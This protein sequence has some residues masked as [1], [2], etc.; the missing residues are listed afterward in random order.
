MQREDVV[1]PDVSGGN[2]GSSSLTLFS[3]TQTKVYSKDFP[4]CIFQF[5]ECT[6]ESTFALD[7]TLLP[8]IS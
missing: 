3:F 5:K 8:L 7:D 6:A 2:E 4:A 1:Y